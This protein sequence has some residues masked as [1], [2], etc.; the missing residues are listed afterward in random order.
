MFRVKNAYALA[1]QD[2]A[3]RKE[4]E[5]LRVEMDTHT[6]PAERLPFLKSIDA[7]T[8]E[9]LTTLKKMLDEIEAAGAII[10]P[11]ATKNAMEDHKAFW[12]S[13]GGNPD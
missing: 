7:K 4:I 9:R 10:A 3:T 1:A 12:R 13:V 6:D 8:L 11:Y 5:K 2:E